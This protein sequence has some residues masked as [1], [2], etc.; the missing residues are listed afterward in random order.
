MKEDKKLINRL[1]G[2][3]IEATPNALEGMTLEQLTECYMTLQHMRDVIS[4]HK[5]QTREISDAGR[6][7]LTAISEFQQ[8][9]G[10][11]V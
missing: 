8:T 1:E 7:V 5:Y 10:V 9:V 2:M 3:A 6:Q 11:N 4:E